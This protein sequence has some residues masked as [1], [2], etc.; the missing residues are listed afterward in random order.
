MNLK[1]KVKIH[2][3]YCWEYR[4]VSIFLPH[5]G[6]INCLREQI[7][8]LYQKRKYAFF[9]TR[10]YNSAILL[11]YGE[12]YLPGCLPLFTMVKI[13]KNQKSSTGN[14]LNRSCCER[15]FNNMK[16]SLY[17]SKHWKCCKR[18]VQYNVFL[19]TKYSCV[20]T[21]VPPSPW[22]CFPQFQLPTIN[23]GLKILNGKLQK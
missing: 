17:E 18:N 1:G 11:I 19:K 10:N 14:R 2:T 4:K 3:K 9:F 23:R 21:V 22:F 16:D 12:I 8:H 13:G 6:S 20:Y 15:I 7:S 5:C